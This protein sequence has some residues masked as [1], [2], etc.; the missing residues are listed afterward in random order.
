MGTRHAAVGSADLDFLDPD[1]RRIGGYFVSGITVEQVRASVGGAGLVD[2]TVTLFC[3]DLLPAAR[4]PWE[5]VRSGRL[6]ALGLWRPLDRAGRHAWLSVALHRHTCADDPPGRRYVLDGRDIV[7]E[8]SFYCAL[9]E[10]V[11]G[12]GGYFGWNLDALADCLRGGFGAT[13]PFTLEWTESSRA[14]SALAVPLPWGDGTFF[15]VVLEILDSG[16]VEVLLR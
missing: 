7:D 2:V 5:L 9:G 6:D 10:A 3:D 16:K 8:D 1:G 13:P 11:N 15:D 12:P 4:W 14:R